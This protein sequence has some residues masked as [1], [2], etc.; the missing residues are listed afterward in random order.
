M[1]TRKEPSASKPLKPFLV[2]I[3]ENIES[4]Y[5]A[6]SVSNLEFS[7]VGEASHFLL[8]QVED[9]K[10]KDLTYLSIEFENIFGAKPTDPEELNEYYKCS[11]AG[12][13]VNV[14][15]HDEICLSVRFEFDFENRF[16]KFSFPEINVIH[17]YRDELSDVLL[18]LEKMGKK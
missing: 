14:I 1:T 13:C 3:V 2:E 17:S 8:K 16:L 7:D 9:L 4:Y 5:F 12:I 18:K 15:N 11:T 6:T 10:F